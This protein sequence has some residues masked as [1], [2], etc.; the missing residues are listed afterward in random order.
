[1]Y[2][3]KISETSFF[4]KSIKHLFDKFDIQ[5]FTTLPPQLLA[6]SSTS[7]HTHQ[8]HHKVLFLSFTI[9]KLTILDLF[10]SLDVHAVEEIL[11]EPLSS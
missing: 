2:I 3:Y 1:M 11:M 4:I 10:Q 8:P 7:P 9:V 5:N 6:Q